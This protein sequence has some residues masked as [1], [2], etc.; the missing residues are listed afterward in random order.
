MG[1][2]GPWSLLP[3]CTR[4]HN[5]H[6]FLSITFLLFYLHVNF[7]F[8]LFD[9]K[10]G[11]L[12]RISFRVAQDECASRRPCV[13]GDLH[14]KRPRLSLTEHHPIV[15]THT[16]VAGPQLPHWRRRHG[17][18]PL[19]HGGFGTLRKEE[20]LRANCVLHIATLS[21]AVTHWLEFS[22]ALESSRSF[23]KG[24]RYERILHTLSSADKTK[25]RAKPRATREDGCQANS[26]PLNSFLLSLKAV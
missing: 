12:P 23:N 3:H 16:P 7:H 10:F 19:T 4:A 14:I 20:R 9:E 1:M 26:A 25:R 6:G 13:G 22:P 21:T 17:V 18:Q 15:W 24:P 8:P 5:R 11:P 2:K